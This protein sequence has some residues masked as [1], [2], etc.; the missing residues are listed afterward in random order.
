MSNRDMRNHGW[1]ALAFVA[2]SAPR[3]PVHT[4]AP[5]SRVIAPVAVYDDES[6]PPNA[7]FW[8]DR[9]RFDWYVWL[10][11]R[12]FAFRYEPHWTGV[13]HARKPD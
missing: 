6:A 11:R 8:L 4:S 9:L 12:G 3:P 10:A 1:I 5:A 2:C 13:H 7:H